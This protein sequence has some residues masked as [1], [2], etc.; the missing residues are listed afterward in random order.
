MEQDQFWGVNKKL[1]WTKTPM[2]ALNSSL[3]I[4]VMMSALQQDFQAEV[5]HHNTRDCEL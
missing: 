4:G 2:V 1:A 3:V 5:E